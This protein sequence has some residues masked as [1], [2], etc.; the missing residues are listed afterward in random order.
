MTQQAQRIDEEVSFASG[1]LFASIVAMRPAS[2]RGFHR[3]TI[4]NGRTRC[5]LASALHTQPLP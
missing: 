5:R 2:L 1:E 3:L 4:K